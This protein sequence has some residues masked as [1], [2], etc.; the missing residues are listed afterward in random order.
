MCGYSYLWNHLILP[1]S[2]VECVAIVLKC[3]VRKAFDN[4]MRHERAKL[5]TTKTC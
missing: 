2:L 3:L 4:Y 5:S 1:H